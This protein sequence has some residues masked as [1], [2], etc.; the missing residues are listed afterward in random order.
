M[1][2]DIVQGYLSAAEAAGALLASPALAER[3]EQ[4]S[5]LEHWS[6]AGLAGHLARAV[7]TVQDALTSPTGGAPSVEDAVDY[8]AAAAI[9]DASPDSD[10]AARIRERGVALALTQRNCS[11]ATWPASSR[12]A[13]SWPRERT[14]RP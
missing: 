3:W 11:P 7:F 2:H 1:Q 14:P 10:V 5:V 4:P 9:E 6:V 12:C 8:Y 13:G